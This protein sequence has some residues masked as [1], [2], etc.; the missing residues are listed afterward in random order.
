M[1][2]SNHELFVPI[3]TAIVD[4]PRGLKRVK[5]ARR[6]LALLQPEQVAAL[7]LDVGSEWTQEIATQ[8]KE[9]ALS[10]EAVKQ[11]VRWLQ[12]AERTEHE[13]RERLASKDYSTR[14]V[15]LALQHLRASG[16]WSNERTRD[17]V[18]RKLADQGKS[19]AFIREALAK[20]GVLPRNQ[21]H[22]EVRDRVSD[23]AGDEKSRALSVARKALQTSGNDPA[24]SLRKALGA[25]ARAGYDEEAARDAIIASAPKAVRMLLEEQ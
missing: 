11:C 14:V 8:A 21:A 4:A 5:A 12:H 19:A 3:V 6:T 7:R 23:N 1:A 2:N 9:L 10:N 17:V 15:E 24:K 18:E 22:S 13:L 25:L 16:L 20:R